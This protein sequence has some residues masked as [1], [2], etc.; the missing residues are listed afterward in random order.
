M[1]DIEHERYRLNLENIAKETKFL[2][3][4]R[5]LASRLLGNPYMSVE[6][7]LTAL[8]PDDLSLLLDVCEHAMSLDEDEEHEV[9]RID[10]LVLISNMLALGEGLDNADLDTAMNRTNQLSVFL[11]LESLKRKGLAKLYYENMSFGED[12]N[13]KVIAEKP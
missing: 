1:T 6:E 12:F 11:T 5:F 8:T 10:E 13:D 9:T 4:T 2:A 7:F 3:V